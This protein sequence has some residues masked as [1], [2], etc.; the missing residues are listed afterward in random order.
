MARTALRA[1]AV[2]S[3]APVNANRS[4][5]TDRNAEGCPPR[6]DTPCTAALRF[7]ACFF[8]GCSDVGTKSGGSWPG[9]A[10]NKSLGRLVDGTVA[11]VVD[12]GAEAGEVTVVVVSVA[13][14]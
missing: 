1:S 2:L 10:M 5:G 12:G 4:F 11:V 14:A 3:D 13:M 7:R 8:V 9:S 6:S